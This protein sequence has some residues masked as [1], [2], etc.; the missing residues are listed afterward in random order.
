LNIRSLNYLFNI[1]ADLHKKI[2]FVS[3]VFLSM[4]SGLQAQVGNAVEGQ[5][6]AISCS[7]CHGADG[8]SMMGDWPS[9]AGQ[10]ESYLIT[11]ITAMRDGLRVNLLMA[12]FVAGLSDEDIIDL[13]A[14]YASQALQPK[15][16]NSSFVIQGQNIYLSGDPSR[17]LPACTSC[18][19]PDGKGNPFSGYPSL[20]GQ[21]ASYTEIQLNAYASGTRKTIGNVQIMYD[22]ASLLS[23]EEIEAVSNFVQGLR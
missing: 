11:Q 16:T 15:T 17:N 1:T 6:K 2:Y 14:Y 12:P 5:Q 18:H 8:N 21:H 13:S 20:A 3:V 4:V 19:G 7:A 9:L 10:H 23:S 22:I